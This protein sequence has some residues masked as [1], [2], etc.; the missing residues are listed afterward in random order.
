MNRRLSA[1]R[2]LE[3]LLMAGRYRL[4]PLLPEAYPDGQMRPVL[5]GAE[6]EGE[7]YVERIER[8]LEEEY[9]VGWRF[10]GTFDGVYAVF[11]AREV[12]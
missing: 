5:G 12:T 9:D 1:V 10:V 7:T 8:A 2:G 11:E 4:V 3:G 6:R